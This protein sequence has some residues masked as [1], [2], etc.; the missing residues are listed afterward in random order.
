MRENDIER[1]K[2]N[3]KT[4]VAVYG[5]LKKGGRFHSNMQEMK[6]KKLEGNYLA[7][8]FQLY[9]VDRRGY[10]AVKR[11]EKAMTLVE[12]YEVDEFI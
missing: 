5:T 3:M 1:E 7:E 11:D 10:P 2:E 8:G 4:L 6:A 12:L 9:I